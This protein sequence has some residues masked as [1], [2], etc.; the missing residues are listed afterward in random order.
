MS[1]WIA[2]AVLTLLTG[3]V[4]WRMK[5]PLLP[6]GLA[7]ATGLAGYLLTSN[8]ALPSKPAPPRAI[9]ADSAPQL[10][11]ARQR[12][13]QNTGDVGAWLMFADILS[14]Q[15]KT[16]Q[17]ID[18]ISLAAWHSLTGRFCESCGRGWDRAATSKC[19]DPVKNRRSRTNSC[20][21]SWRLPREV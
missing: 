8:P 11:A 14:H 21:R 18:G 16:E 15:G 17:A 13:L 2:I 5:M 7:L 6:V 1:G 10:E 4:L 12:L 20:S 19:R 9:D 3:A